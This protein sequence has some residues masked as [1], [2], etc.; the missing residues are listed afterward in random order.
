MIL[1]GEVNL[2]NKFKKLKNDYIKKTKENKTNIYAQMGMLGVSP[3][4]L[5]MYEESIN[6]IQKTKRNSKKNIL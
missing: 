2:E 6:K 4:H 1:K 3:K 5:E